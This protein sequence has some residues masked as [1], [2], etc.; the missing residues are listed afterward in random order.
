MFVKVNIISLYKIVL[1]E[2]TLN[3]AFEIKFRRVYSLQMNVK[4]NELFWL[5][6]DLLG[7]LAQLSQSRKEKSPLSSN[8]TGPIKIN[9]KP[10]R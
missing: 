2:I 1:L 7:L 8:G 4:E 3:A 10:A 9:H 5:L 6:F